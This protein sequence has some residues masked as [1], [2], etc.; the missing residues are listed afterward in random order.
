MTTSRHCKKISKIWQS[1]WTVC[2][3]RFSPSPPET[4]IKHSL[5]SP[6]DARLDHLRASHSVHI[7]CY[8]DST[9][10]TNGILHRTNR[11]EGSKAQTWWH[12]TFT[13][14]LSPCCSTI[15]LEQFPP[16]WIHCISRDHH[17]AHELSNH[18]RQPS[19]EIGLWSIGAPGKMVHSAQVMLN[20]Y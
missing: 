2:T 7:Y 16:A 11:A 5:H 18:I 20:C 3:T 15:Q 12:S 17:I 9:G 10:R 8:S 4:I 6:A 13:W 19:Q 1:P 14:N